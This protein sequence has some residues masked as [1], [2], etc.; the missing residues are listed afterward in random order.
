MGS[1]VSYV[2]IPALALTLW[3]LKAMAADDC[4]RAR[5]HYSQGTKL[6][7]YDARRTAFAKAVELCPSYVEAHVNLA[8]A[9]EHLASI[10]YERAGAEKK[11]EDRAR[12]ENLKKSREFFERA[13]EEYSRALELRPD[14]YLPHLGLAQVYAARGLYEKARQEYEKALQLKPGDKRVTLGLEFVKRTIAREQRRDKGGLKKASDIVALVQESPLAAEMSVMGPESFTVVKE[15][16]RFT[17]IIFDGWSSE[18]R[19]PETLNQLREIGAAL[20][21]RDLDAYRFVVEGHANTVGL[22]QPGGFEKLME[23]SRD[24]AR[25]VKRYLV[26]RYKLDGDRI[27]TQG[28]GCTRLRFPDNSPVHRERNRRVEVVFIKGK[29]QRREGREQ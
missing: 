29:E 22:D 21:S 16:L 20:A 23:L 15:R 4:E 13:R 2:L 25:A 3:P 1:R 5:S 18:I 6:Y 24:R 19:R 11:A 8:D 27:I 12:Q 17:N 28:F 26:A 10:A 7:R 9:L 14:Y